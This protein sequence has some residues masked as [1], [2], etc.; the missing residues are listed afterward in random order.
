MPKR[1]GESWWPIAAEPHATCFSTGPSN[2]CRSPAS[3]P[4]SPAE[5]LPEAVSRGY[6]NGTSLLRFRPRKGPSTVEVAVDGNGRLTREPQAKTVRVL[7][8]MSC[9]PTP[10][11]LGLTSFSSRR[12]SR[13]HAKVTP[14]KHGRLSC[15]SLPPLDRTGGIQFVSLRSVLLFGFV[16][17]RQNGGPVCRGKG[18]RQ[19]SPPSRRRKA[20]LGGG[21]NF[22]RQP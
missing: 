5:S 7:M 4:T 12:S 1:F 22:R 2:S 20:V 10:S 19:T 14:G 16:V 21:V 13:R 3:R 18:E 6:Q 17:R 8:M 11:G 9:V 15:P